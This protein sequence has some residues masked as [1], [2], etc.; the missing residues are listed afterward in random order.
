LSMFTGHSLKEESELWTAFLR[1]KK[2]RNT[3]VHEGIIRSDATGGSLVGVAHRIINKVREWL[4]PE[5]QWKQNNYDAT[6]EILHHSLTP[7][8]N[9][10]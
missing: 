10:D 5:I 1:L 7:R 8:R 4:P 3:F 2:A 9:K 6:I